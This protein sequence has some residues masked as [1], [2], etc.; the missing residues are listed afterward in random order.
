MMFKD[1]ACEFGSFRFQDAA[2]NAGVL[3]D[4]GRI[5]AHVDNTI[6]TPFRGVI[7]RKTQAGERL[8]PPVGTVKR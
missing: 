3:V 1:D 5:R 4:D 7:Q 6:H 2:D 8:A